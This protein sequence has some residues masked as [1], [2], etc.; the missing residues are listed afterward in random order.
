MVCTDIQV[1]MTAWLASNKTCLEYTGIFQPIRAGVS[2]SQSVIRYQTGREV[3]LVCWC[4]Y[5]TSR[6]GCR[7][8]ETRDNVIGCAKKLWRYNNVIID[9]G[10]LW[11]FSHLLLGHVEP[12]WGGK[13]RSK[14]KGWK[15]K[16][17]NMGLNIC[18]C[19]S[20]N[21]MNHFKESR[22]I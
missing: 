2:M 14:I 5:V 3:T 4:S 12:T 18:F 7:I 21:C 20:C 19:K 8:L 22:Q 15:V 16:M 13:Y 10:L 1:V 6:V 9:K 17:E 11:F